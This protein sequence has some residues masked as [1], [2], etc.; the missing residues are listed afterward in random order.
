MAEAGLQWPK[1]QSKEILLLLYVIVSEFVML[2]NKTPSAVK[3][4]IPNKKII[5]KKPN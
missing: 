5:H 1:A 3:R 2:E 4:P